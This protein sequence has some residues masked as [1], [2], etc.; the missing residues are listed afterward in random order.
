VLLLSPYNNSSYYRLSRCGE[1][2]PRGVSTGR[3]LQPQRQHIDQLAEKRRSPVGLNLPT[4]APSIH[5]LFDVKNL[6]YAL[7]NG[8]SSLTC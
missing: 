6:N 1:G 3:L 4:G 7:G 2:K 8:T 5:V